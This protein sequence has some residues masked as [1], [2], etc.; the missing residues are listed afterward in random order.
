MQS[1][2]CTF[3]WV[4]VR[5]QG[6]GPML[7][8]NPERGPWSKRD[9]EPKAV[10]PLPQNWD[11][12]FCSPSSTAWS[13]FQPWVLKQSILSHWEPPWG[14][15][16][17]AHPQSDGSNLSPDPLGWSLI[18]SSSDGPSTD[19]SPQIWFSWWLPLPLML[20]SYSAGGNINLYSLCGGPSAHIYNNVT[21]TCPW[22]CNSAFKNLVH[23]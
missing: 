13:I 19:P 21:R 20:A 14:S 1:C 9:G 12:G 7:L 16:Y 5:T 2:M 23:R 10:I 18:L 15:Y 11:K 8:S 4:C 17:P 6:T 3:V 22:F